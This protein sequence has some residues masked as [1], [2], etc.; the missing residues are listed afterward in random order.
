MRRFDSR[1]LCRNNNC[2]YVCDNLN[3]NSSVEKDEKYFEII[4]K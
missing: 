2:T 3:R 4:G 1:Y